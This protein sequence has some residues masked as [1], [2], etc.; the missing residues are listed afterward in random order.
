VWGDGKFKGTR[1]VSG[2]SISITT[3]AVSVN[4]G[5]RY[6]AVYVTNKVSKYI[7]ESVIGKQKRVVDVHLAMRDYWPMAVR[8]G[9]DDQHLT[10]TPGIEFGKPVD[11]D[12][13]I[14]DYDEMPFSFDGENEIDPRIWIAADGPCTILALSYGVI[15]EGESREDSSR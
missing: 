6:N 8:V 5:L 3:G 11:D 14:T 12:T 4:V 7:N 13:I 10:R 15:T 9:P 1:T 2:G